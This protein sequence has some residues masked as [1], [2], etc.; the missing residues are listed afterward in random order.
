MR[1][2]MKRNGSRPVG[3]SDAA[4]GDAGAARVERSPGTN[5]TVGNPCVGR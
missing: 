5:W 4:A 1:I 2:T 3:E